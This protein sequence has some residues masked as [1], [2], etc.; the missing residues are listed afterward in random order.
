[1]DSLM[2]FPSARASATFFAAFGFSVMMSS[3]ICNENMRMYKKV[4]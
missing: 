3:V 1:M 4:H 2:G